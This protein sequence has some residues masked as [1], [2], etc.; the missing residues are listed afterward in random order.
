M[1]SGRSDS[2]RRLVARAR[3]GDEAA[4]EGIYERSHPRLLAFCQHLT[5]Q[6]EDAEDAVQYTFLAAYRE[7]G[8]SSRTLDL[9]PWLFTVAG[10]RCRSLMRARRVRETQARLEAAAFEGETL[11]EQV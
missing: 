11:A 2:D 7:I 1:L 5:G 4:F 10:N 8:G 9:R 6:R 3:A